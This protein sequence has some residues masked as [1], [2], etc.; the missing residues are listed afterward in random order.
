MLHEAYGNI[1]D[2]VPLAKAGSGMASVVDD[3]DDWDLGDIPFSKNAD[4]RASICVDFAATQSWCRK[5]HIHVPAKAGAVFSLALQGL[6]ELHA[7]HET[8]KRIAG[9]GAME[10]EL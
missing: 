10:A 2:K 5:F 6:G 1:A 4:V 9:L 7:A 3:D 8:K